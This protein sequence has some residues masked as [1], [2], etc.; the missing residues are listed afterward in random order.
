M[1]PINKFKDNIK[2]SNIS[3]GMQLT[4][5]NYNIGYLI[6]SISPFNGGTERVTLTITERLKFYGFDAFFIYSLIDY[7]KIE[8]SHKLKISEKD[9]ELELYEIINNY[10]QKNNIRILVIVNQRFQTQKYQKIY[11][12]LK[13]NNPTLRIIA[14]LHASPDYWINKDKWGCVMKRVFF[15]NY[16]KS[17]ILRFY[18]P[19]KIK[20]IGM[21][22]LCD[23]FHLLSY[24]YID[25]FQKVYNISD[26][27]QKL[28]SIPNPC[29]FNDIPCV[30]KENIVLV[31]SRIDEGQKRISQVLKI[32]SNVCNDND[33]WKLV[34]VGD[35]PNLKDYKRMAAKMSI[36]NV[37]F[38]GHSN[39]VSEYYNK[40][41]IFLMTSIWEGLPMTLI[42]AQHYGC[43]PIVYDNFDALKD[44]IIN[45]K[46]GFIITPNDRVNFVSTLRMLMERPQLLQ[47]ISNNILNQNNKL[48]SIE[49]VISEWITLYKKLL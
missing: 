22:K 14:S 30:E 39:K 40:S 17:V 35:G 9:N 21:Y 6:G 8:Q 19:Y 18:N 23:K 44:I 10:I 29:P 34:I 5:H 32:W 2:R 4:S 33:E 45:G 12:S 15:K 13:R 16:I 11:K 28:I 37:I 41:K 27:A 47:N 7:S 38:M 36:K 3:I 48:F 25:T 43:V 49:Y 20:S 42:E 24:S 46:T 1:K 26:D 31:V